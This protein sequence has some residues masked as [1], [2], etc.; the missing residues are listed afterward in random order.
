M[1]KTALAL[2]VGGLFAA[3]AAQAQI[4]FGNETL[5]TLQLYGKLYPQFG[6]GS[7]KDATKTGSPVSTLVSPNG[8]C[9]TSGSAGGCTGSTQGSRNTVDVQNS[10]IGFR[11]ERTI[12][13]PLKFI[14]QIEQAV[15]FDTGDATWSNRNSF[16]GA[17]TNFGTV[18][19]GNM[20]TIYKEYGD[21]FQMFGISSGN[22]VSASNVLSQIG[23]G[24]SSTARFHERKAN[25]IQYETPQIAGFTGG[26]QYSPDEQRDTTD[27]VPSGGCTTG[28]GA[29]NCGRDASL[30][31]F[32]VKW[33]S[34]KL[35]AS[36]HREIHNDFF[37]GSN[38][39]SSTLSNAGTNGAHSRDTGTRFSTE[40]RFVENQRVTFD[41]SR[42][43]YRERGQVA[44]APKFERYK[45]NTWAVGWDGGFGGPLRLAAQYV[46]G[47]SG[48]CNLTGGFACSTDGLKSWMLNLGARWRFDRQT[49]IYA[50]AGKLSN[51]A[52]ARYDNWAA[53]DPARGAD[54]YQA[55][56][57]LSYTF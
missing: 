48:S 53:A 57:G 51:G 23:V 2:A 3:P 50:I 29:G 46:R 19:L 10:Y 8:I 35:Y 36:V 15:N 40:W 24:R 4:V 41:I 37:G 16:L 14:W 12:S 38:N 42:L 20:D 28:P 47:N 18:K 21:T 52:S 22:F 39:V 17:R 5:G 26:Y 56:L 13:A 27:T 11:G 44:P 43:D 9:G 7:S 1:R 33:D 25:S 31:S 30:H 6:Y 32:G 54:I 45:H 49:F 55:A 34:E